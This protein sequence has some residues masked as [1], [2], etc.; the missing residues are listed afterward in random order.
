M[1]SAKVGLDPGGWPKLALPG[2]CKSGP[3]RRLSNDETSLATLCPNPT[4]SPERVS[5]FQLGPAHLLELPTARSNP[6]SLDSPVPRLLDAPNRQR[7]LRK[8]RVPF[9][10]ATVC[11]M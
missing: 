5:Q 3:G 9:L 2:Q 8:T 6:A 7:S 10:C 11:G 4:A 1:A